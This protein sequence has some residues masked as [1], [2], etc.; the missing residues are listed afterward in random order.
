MFARTRVML[1]DGEAGLTSKSAQTI[2]MQR[3]GLSVRAEPGFKRNTA[4]RY[5]REFKTR[6]VIGL[7]IK[8]MLHISPK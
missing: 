6:T 2:C 7:D 8:G 1:F 5:I 4:E 3:F